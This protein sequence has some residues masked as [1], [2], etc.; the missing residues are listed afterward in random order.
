MSKEEADLQITC[1]QGVPVII[2]KSD[3]KKAL[4]EDKD[5]ELGKS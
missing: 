3:K 4:V 1:R 2:G 5:A